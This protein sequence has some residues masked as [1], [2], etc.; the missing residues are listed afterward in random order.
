[1]IHGSVYN[2]CI[3]RKDNIIVT[4]K[5]LFSFM[6]SKNVLCR[7]CRYISMVCTLLDCNPKKLHIS[8]VRKNSLIKV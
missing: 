2:L 3:T 5:I 6:C 1:M 4:I 7:C 8:I